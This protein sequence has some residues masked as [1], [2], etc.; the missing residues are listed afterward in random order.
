MCMGKFTSTMIGFHLG[1]SPILTMFMGTLKITASCAMLR[2]IHLPMG[3]AHCILFASGQFV[4][5]KL[6]GVAM[7]SLL[8]E[9]QHGT[10]RCTQ[11]IA[12]GILCLCQQLT[13]RNAHTP[14]CILHAIRSWLLFVCLIK[15]ALS[16][17]ILGTHQAS[18][19]MH[20]TL[21]CPLV[22]ALKRG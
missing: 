3:A 13:N 8:V 19:L 12:G 20:M 5:K 6:I 9:G 21:I 2:Y 18:M 15:C 10:K 11:E 16:N 22:A 1:N 14:Q 7:F 17:K 4:E